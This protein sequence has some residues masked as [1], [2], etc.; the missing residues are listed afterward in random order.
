MLR[1]PYSAVLSFGR[2]STAL[3]NGGLAPAGGGYIASG[4]VNVCLRCACYF[5]TTSI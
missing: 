4:V 3:V 5:A 1:R 2:L